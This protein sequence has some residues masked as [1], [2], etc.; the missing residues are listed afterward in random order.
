[1]N[2]FF[3]LELL[4]SLCCA[5]YFIPMQNDVFNNERKE[6]GALRGIF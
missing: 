4:K 6:L 1:M 5:M 2:A 3:P